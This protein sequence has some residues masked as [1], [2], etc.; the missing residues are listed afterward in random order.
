MAE[1]SKD[2]NQSGHFIGSG[3]RGN[4]TSGA[5]IGEDGTEKPTV[6]IEWASGKP[7]A[8]E[9]AAA[10]PEEEPVTS[11]APERIDIEEGPLWIAATL[12]RSL[13]FHA[14]TSPNQPAGKAWFFPSADTYMFNEK[15]W[16]GACLLMADQL[17]SMAEQESV[18]DHRIDSPY[19]DPQVGPVLAMSGGN[20][21]TVKENNQDTE[22][23][24]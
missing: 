10:E 13:P 11:T 14:F 6:A 17:R 5:L 24:E 1:I 18:I 16:S 22:E 2:A 20:F 9:V 23:E 19:D 7:S 4:T 21:M 8:S 12:L 3:G 15:D